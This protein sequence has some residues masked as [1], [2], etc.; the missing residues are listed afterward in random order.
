MKTPTKQ[1]CDLLVKQINEITLTQ[2][3]FQTKKIMK[4]LK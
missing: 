3:G 4:T 2:S 1:T